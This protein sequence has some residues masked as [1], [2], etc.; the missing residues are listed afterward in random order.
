MF[1]KLEKCVMRIIERKKMMKVIRNYKHIIYSK[2]E[3]RTKN[4]MIKSNVIEV[5]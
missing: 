2:S 4:S 5:K 3:E 1:S